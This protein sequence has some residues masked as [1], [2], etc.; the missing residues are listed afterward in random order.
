MKFSNQIFDNSIVRFQ[1]LLKKLNQK[2]KCYV[3][4]AKLIILCTMQNSFALYLNNILYRDVV[5]LIF[6][7][8]E[9]FHYWKFELL[10]H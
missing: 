3:T 7:E 10:F 1:Y 9:C 8:T 6:F 2:Y 4:F 5:L